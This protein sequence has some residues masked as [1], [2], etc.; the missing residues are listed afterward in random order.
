MT[1][2]GRAPSGQAL[3]VPATPA[4]AV[5]G[6]SGF[7]PSRITEAVQAVEG[8][9]LEPIIRKAADE[10]YNAMLGTAEDYLR[11]NLDWNLRSHLG[12]LEREN[13]RMRTELWDIDRKLGSRPI[14]DRLEAIGSLETAS[15]RYYEL[16]YAVSRKYEGEDRHET[17]LRYIRERDSDGSGEA[18]ETPKSGS[19]EGDSAGLKGIAQNQS[20]SRL[21][22]GL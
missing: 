7:D 17:A 10:F 18:G 8:K 6:P 5:D 21:G 3:A 2:I 11:E 16:L 22:E 4:N 14:P 15:R 13:Q 12:M 9:A 1:D 19:T 20:A